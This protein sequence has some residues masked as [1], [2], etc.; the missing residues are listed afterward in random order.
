VADAFEALFEEL[1][2]PPAAGK[3][4]GY[5][6]RYEAGL[7]FAVAD[8]LTAALEEGEFSITP[9]R[10]IARRRIDLVVEA[11]STAVLAIEVNV[12]PPRAPSATAWVSTVRRSLRAQGTGLLSAL[13]RAWAV[14]LV[15]SDGD[16]T[17]DVREALSG[18]VSPV[19]PVPPKRGPLVT[20]QL[21]LVQ[22]QAELERVRQADAPEL[23][24]R[25]ECGQ[26]VA[27]VECTAEGPVGRSLRSR[28]QMFAQGIRPA[29]E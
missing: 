3:P 21:T 18:L 10:R 11:D 13:P 29:G 25:R 19:T 15:F 20:L 23:G 6:R 28:E 26:S 9:E 22:E 2:L 7:R 5:C 8:A 17:S 16:R 14:G 24:S 1:G 4:P 12:A 27:V